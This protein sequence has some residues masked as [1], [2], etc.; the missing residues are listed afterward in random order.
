M[1]VCIHLSIFSLKSNLDFLWRSLKILG[2]AISFSAEINDLAYLKVIFCAGTRISVT[3]SINQ[4]SNPR[5]KMAQLMQSP[6]INL[7]L[8]KQDRGKKKEDKEN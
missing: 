6:G 5:N 7:F 3:Y 1:Y 4:L 2:A 8:T